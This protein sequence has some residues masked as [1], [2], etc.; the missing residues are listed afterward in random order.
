MLPSRVLPPPP[1]VA[2]ETRE[3]EAGPE[4]EE[5]DE[6]D[7]DEEEKEEEGLPFFTGDWKER[8]R[9]RRDIQQIYSKYTAILHGSTTD[10]HL[11]SAW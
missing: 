10:W 8:K 9:Y 1:P 2:R 6:E 3:E 11:L 7:E 5:E 4:A